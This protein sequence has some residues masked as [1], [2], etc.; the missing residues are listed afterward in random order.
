[1]AYISEIE[2]EIENFPFNY[3]IV[4]SD[5]YNS[6]FSNI[7]EVTFYKSLERLSKSDIL[8]HLTKGV[9]YRPFE[10]EYGIVHI[11]EEN[12]VDY[13]T[14]S[15]KGIVIGYDL[16]NRY[17]LSTQ[18]SK[19]YTVLSTTLKENK[20][21][22]GNVNVYKIYINLNREVIRTIE[23]LEILQNYQKIEDVN[24]NAFY[25]FIEDYSKEYREETLDYVLK[26]RN[27]KKATIYFL[28]KCLDLFGVRNNLNKYLSELSSYKIPMLEVL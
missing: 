4:A 24:E 25:S 5:L 18:I 7:P 3:P 2:K 22:F 14:G 9:Y 26:N 13:Y 23:V 19:Q 17:N 1:M 15:N 21:N 11:S 12:I 6:R 8:V 10:S 20:K 27:Y 28:K 16:F